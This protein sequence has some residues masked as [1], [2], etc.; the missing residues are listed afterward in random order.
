MKIC[1]DAGHSKKYNQ[2]PCDGRYYE[3][4]MVW[5]L[6]E[7]QK[8]YLQQYGAEVIT[9]RAGQ[10]TDMGLEGRGLA[11]KGYDLFISNHSNA[12]NGGVNESI[13]YPAAY[14]AING[15]ADQIG[16]LLAQCV[17]TTIGTKQAA[18]IEHKKGQN[19]NY[20][21]VLRGATSAGT[22]GLILEHSFHT[23]SR[24]TTWLLDDNN[25][26]RLAKAE[27]DMIAAFYG[28]TLAV[29]EKKSG[30]HQ[31]GGFWYF[32]LGNTGDRV[33]NDWYEDEDGKWYWF[34]GAG[35]M[36]ANTWYLYKKSWYYLRSDGSMAK[37]L[38]E[39][40]GKWYYLNK[41]GKME[42]EA[43]TLTPDQDGALRH[44]GLAE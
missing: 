31:D 22:P 29:E 37:G 17:E 13:D 8:K 1:L 2:S 14:C 41:D 43:V 20:Y 44:P 3:S 36:V 7:L 18:R 42:T 40:E 24:I 33:A 4:D 27:A 28:L 25:L 19:G 5:K 21:G 9:T 23:N 15:S 12:V 35:Q 26:D 39:S 10:N 11:S 6:T 34:N 38:Q 32:Y 30:W 16:L